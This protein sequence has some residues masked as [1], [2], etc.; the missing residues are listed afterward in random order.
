MAQNENLAELSAAGVAVWLDDLSRDRIRS[1]NLQS[2]VDEYSVVGVTT[3]PTIFAAAISGSDSYDDQVHALAV[4]KVSVEEALRTIT[5]A[6]V[7]DACDLLAPG[8]TTRQPGDGRVS[9]EVG[10][11]P[12][13]RHRRDRRRGRRTCGG[14][15]TGRTCTSRSRRP[16]PACRRSPRR[17]AK[18][19]SV[20]VTLIFSLER[21][22]AVMDA[23]LAGLEKRLAETAARSTA[24]PR[25]PRSSSPASTPRSTSGWTRLGA[26]PSLKGKAG[27]ANAQLAYQAYEEVFSS[28][29]WRAL[30]AK[31]AVPQRPLWASTGVKNPEYSDTMYIS[32]LIA[33]GTVNTMPEK[34]MMAYADH[35]DA[36]ARR[37]RRP[38]TTPPRSCRPS[39]TPASTSTTSSGCSRRR[40][41]R[42]SSTP[43]TS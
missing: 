1:G 27:I 11:R 23:Y 10:P 31:G 2:L 3:N 36:R 22:R 24:S 14:W 4:R 30:E 8:R 6:D 33:P 17:I 35:G 38:T 28:D 19:I 13:A 43:G 41:C 25:W 26:D 7:R 32:E 40:A 42:S 39:P 20:N 21:Y 5:A 34:T 12:G 9:L 16:R 18:G 29:R 15:S 37:C